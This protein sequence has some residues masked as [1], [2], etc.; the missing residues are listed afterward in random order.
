MAGIRTEFSEISGAKVATVWLDRPERKN[1]LSPEMWKE[2]CEAFTSLRDEREV[3]A[4]FIR[5]NCE[6]A[7]CAGLDL[8]GGGM[9]PGGLRE[10][11]REYHV[12]FDAMEDH[13]T[14]VV[15]VLQG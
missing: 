10:T 7:F 12:T 4:V 6:T 3:R 5:S 15:A 13:P 9:S 11:I 2:L 8:G 1:A 14:P